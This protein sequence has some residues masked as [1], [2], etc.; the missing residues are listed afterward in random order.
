MGPFQP[1]AQKGDLLVAVVATLRNV[2]LTYCSLSPGALLLRPGI[3]SCPASAESAVG[4]RLAFVSVR[5]CLAHGHGAW[6]GLLDADLPL[7]GCGR[8][9]EAVLLVRLRIEEA[10][11]Q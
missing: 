4:I 2:S 10:W 1:F 3:C 6:L 9:N 5:P 11:V 8:S 7:I